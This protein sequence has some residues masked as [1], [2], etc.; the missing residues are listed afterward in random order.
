[1]VEGQGDLCPTGI[2]I[3]LGAAGIVIADT[4]VGKG[5][6]N[7]T[8]CGGNTASDVVYR[9]TPS[10]DGTLAV[11]ISGDYD[12]VLAVRDACP[13]GGGDTFCLSGAGPLSDTANVQQGNDVFVVVSG[14]AGAN[15]NYTLQLG[16][17]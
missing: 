14:V 6:G 13:G 1:M 12:M 9:V 2:N 17:N 15:G 3:Q 8:T 7:A 10:Q 4:T 11:S 16:Y 5:A